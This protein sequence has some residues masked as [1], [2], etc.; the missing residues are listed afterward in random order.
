MTE[1]MRSEL[2]LM[3]KRP[4]GYIIGALWTLMVIFFAYVI[5]YIVA[6]TL[7]NPGDASAVMEVISLPKFPATSVGSYPMF[8]GAI[9][10]ILG[11]CITGSE[12]GWGTWKVRFTQGPNRTEIIM[13]K[14]MVGAITAAVIVTIAHIFALITSFIMSRIEQV[15]ESWPSLTFLLASWGAAIAIGI[16]SCW[17]GMMLAILTKNLA[18]AL[19]V[20]LLWTLAFENIIAGL[21]LMW[22]SLSFVQK[23]LLGPAGGSLAHTLGA[24]PMMQGGTPGVVDTHSA[25]IALSI[26]AIYSLIS[27]FIS[28]VIMRRRDIN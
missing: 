27:L 3:R 15:D 9:F 11:A 8:G 6:K 12:F 22:P 4:L 1:A 10:L 13:A 19:S 17:I 18:L 20:G 16:T 24:T 21:S 5:P 25:P 7:P 14:F 23:I 26:L 28:I 2:F